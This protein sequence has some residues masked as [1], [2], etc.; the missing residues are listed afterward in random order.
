MM[1][2]SQQVTSRTAESLLDDD[3]KDVVENP[4]NQKRLAHSVHALD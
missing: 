3:S 1:K 4:R 2:K